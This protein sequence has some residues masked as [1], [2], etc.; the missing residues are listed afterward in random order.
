[1][2]DLRGPH[3]KVAIDRSYHLRPLSA[4]SLPVWETG[5][6]VA[7]FSD[8]GGGVPCAF[9]M[10]MPFLASV[11]HTDAVW[12]FAKT[13]P[14]FSTVVSTSGK[15]AKITAHRRAQCSIDLLLRGDG[16]LRGHLSDL[17]Q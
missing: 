9:Q 15:L 6:G 4:E 12:G 8:V 3:G 17:R 16:D 13:A 1:V 7:T 2:A 11:V 10:S 5:G 14:D